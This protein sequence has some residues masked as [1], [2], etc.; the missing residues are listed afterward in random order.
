MAQLPDGQD[1]R[2]SAAGTG[3]ATGTYG[4]DMILKTMLSGMCLLTLAAK[5]LSAQCSVPFS[6]PGTTI[7]PGQTLFIDFSIPSSNNADL[8]ILS[9]YLPRLVITT[10]TPVVTSDLFI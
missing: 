6:V 9:A 8:L 1:P 4:G 2:L 7:L 3:R 10:G 5:C